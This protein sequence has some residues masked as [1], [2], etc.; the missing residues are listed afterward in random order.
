MYKA[1]PVLVLATI[2]VGFSAHAEALPTRQTGSAAS[3]RNIQSRSSVQ[4]ESLGATKA[5]SDVTRRTSKK[6][7]TSRDPN[8]F[9]GLGDKLDIRVGSRSSR[10]LSG[11]FPQENMLESGGVRVLY[12]LDQE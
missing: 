3:L 5:S 11:V 8:S 1:T 9:F 4:Q 2:I 10:Y 7:A 12:K 6:V